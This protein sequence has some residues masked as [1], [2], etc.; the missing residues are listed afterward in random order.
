MPVTGGIG[1]FIVILVGFIL[2]ALGGFLF[3]K[4]RRGS[5]NG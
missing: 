3:N 5:L 2:V 1:N 4:N